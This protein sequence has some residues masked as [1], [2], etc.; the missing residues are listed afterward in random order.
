MIFLGGRLH[1]VSCHLR[2]S[3]E[4]LVR[5]VEAHEWTEAGD[6]HY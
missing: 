2:L 6:T 3:I 4:A 5:Y 1:Q